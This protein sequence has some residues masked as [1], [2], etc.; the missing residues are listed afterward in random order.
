MSAMGRLIE[1]QVRCVCLI[2][3]LEIFS[4]GQEGAGPVRKGMKVIKTSI[5]Y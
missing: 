5:D 1:E 2:R 4:Q 3:L